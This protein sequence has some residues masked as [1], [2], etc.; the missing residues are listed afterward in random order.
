MINSQPPTELRYSDAD[1][2]VFCVGAD[3]MASRMAFSSND[4]PN[5][6]IKT[7]WTLS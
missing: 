1:S 7:Q 5:G 4:G 2:V 6:L 3:D